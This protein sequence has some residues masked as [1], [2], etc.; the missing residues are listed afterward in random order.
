M[1]DIV[2]IVHRC[3]H[4]ARHPG[5]VV[6]NHIEGEVRVPVAQH[7]ALRF[8]MLLL[9]FVDSLCFFDIMIAFMSF[10]NNAAP[11]SLILNLNIISNNDFSASLTLLC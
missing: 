5:G 1:V 8:L 4:L 10:C 9:I 3:S 7:L 2:N 11:E 6:V